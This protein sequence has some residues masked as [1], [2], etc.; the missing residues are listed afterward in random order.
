MRRAVA[1]R[2][3]TDAKQGEAG[4]PFAYPYP[5]GRERQAIFN[6]FDKVFSTL[7][8]ETTEQGTKLYQSSYNETGSFGKTIKQFFGVAGRGDKAIYKDI[9]EALKNPKDNVGKIIDLGYVPDIYAAIGFS[10]KE[11]KATR[12]TFLKA[13][14]KLSKAQLKKYKTHNHNVPKKILRNIGTLIADP[15]MILESNSVSGRL[16]AVLDASVYIKGKGHLPVVVV[17]SPEPKSGGYSFIPSV[18]EHDNLV[19]QI[20]DAD[21]KYVDYGKSGILYIDKNRVPKCLAYGV[22]PQPLSMWTSLAHL[23]TPMNSILSKEDIVKRY[24]LTD[25]SSQTLH[26]SAK[27]NLPETIEIEGEE[28]STRN[29]EG[30][31]I[32]DTEEGIRNFY[33]W[34]GNSKAVDKAGRP[35]VVYHGGGNDIKIFDYSKIGQQGRSEGS[36]FEFTAN[37]DLAQGYADRHGGGL[38]PVYLRIER[39]ILDLDQTTLSDEQKYNFLELFNDKVNQDEEYVSEMGEDSVLSDYGSI[40]GALSAVQYDKD[41][42]VVN[43]FINS[44]HRNKEILE[45]FAEVAY[46]G[47]ILTNG[48][49]W[50]SNGLYVVFNNNQIKS[51]ENTG[52]FDP[53]NPNIFYQSSKEPAIFRREDYAWA[54][55]KTG[56]N[57]YAIRKI[58]S[59]IG[60]LMKELQKRKIDPET[61][62]RITRTLRSAIGYKGYLYLL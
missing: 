37:K 20:N 19:K 30:G 8:W 48:S 32:A 7:K 49:E 56:D 5:V 21:K 9:L 41:L 61:K 51:V 52:K 45:A 28:K 2:I 4:D 25:D 27:S 39:P 44:T 42:D 54:F 15:L 57:R 17:I 58:N 14:G 24:G 31:L 12:L 3:N 13:N 55:R 60:S 16:L 1:E 18:Y 46:D 10:G 35:L 62:E 33:K 59:V 22:K 11:L 50:H 53:G 23:S 6:A 47:V 36:G 38:Y 43:E 29:S 40:D 34:F 26:Q